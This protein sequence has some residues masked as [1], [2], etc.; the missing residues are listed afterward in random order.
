M[1][2]TT[3]FPL[4]SG[5]VLRG[6]I[7]LLV[8]WCATILLR[9]RSASLRHGVWAAAILG[10]FSIPVL[11]WALPA[12]EILPQSLAVTQIL[13]PVPPVAPTAPTATV[14]PVAPVPR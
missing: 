3:Y 8:A 14:A 9:H 1:D 6:M 2:V 10:T 7:I 13:A 4:L 11:A 5:W 12:W